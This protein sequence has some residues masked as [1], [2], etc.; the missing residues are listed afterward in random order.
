M[1]GVPVESCLQLWLWL[2]LWSLALTESSGWAA[3]VGIFL[4]V[5]LSGAT[6]ETGLDQGGGGG[7]ERFPQ[8][9]HHL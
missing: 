9:G 2:W 8:V 7:R 3:D 6:Q 1:V 5:L 4:T